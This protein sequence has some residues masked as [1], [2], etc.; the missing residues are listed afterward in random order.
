[1]TISES[2]LNA[3]RLVLVIMVSVA[4]LAGL[5]HAY[6]V[7]VD[8]RAIYRAWRNNRQPSR[9]VRE[10]RLEEV[11]AEVGKQ[12]GLYRVIVFIGYSLL[13]LCSLST[14]SLMRMV[15][16]PFALVVAI[17]VHVYLTYREHAGRQQLDQITRE[18][19]AS[20]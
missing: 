5:L 9:S 10:R 3:A 13:A 16:G 14:D 17:T 19:D 6:M 15:V 18:P 7:Y 4:S 2:A 11:I 20:A 8:A 1:M 12:T